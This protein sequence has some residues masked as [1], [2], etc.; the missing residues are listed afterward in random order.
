LSLHAHY[1]MTDPVAA[2]GRDLAHLRT[3]TA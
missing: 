1:P 3:L 2:V